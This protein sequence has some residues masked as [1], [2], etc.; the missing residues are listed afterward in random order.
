MGLERG[1]D[2]SLQRWSS[3]RHQPLLP[4]ACCNEHGGVSAKLR[5][6][7]VELRA[8]FGERVLRKDTKKNGEA[9]DERHRDGTTPRGA[10]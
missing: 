9:S 4:L 8:S 5:N 2:S 3:W 1:R 7:F 6:A 10:V